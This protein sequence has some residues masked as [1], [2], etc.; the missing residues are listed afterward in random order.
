MWILRF[1]KDFCG[2]ALWENSHD[3]DHS[4]WEKDISQSWRKKDVL[5]ILVHSILLLPHCLLSVRQI[6]L[7]PPNG[8]PSFKKM[9]IKVQ[10]ARLSLKATT[11]LSSLFFVQLSFF[12]WW[13]DPPLPWQKTLKSEWLST[14][15]L[16]VDFGFF[17][18]LTLWNPNQV[19]QLK[20]KPL[21]RVF[22]WLSNEAWRG[23]SDISPSWFLMFCG[24]MDRVTCFVTC[25]PKNV[26]VV[27]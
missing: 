3:S 24:M 13:W 22:F 4:R 23:F 11:K 10:G 9:I 19:G 26:C 25:L 17:Q 2:V 5:H 18:S 14:Y 8:H 20:K 16:Q 7:L 27:P 12:G 6:T 21:Q 15:S 1:A